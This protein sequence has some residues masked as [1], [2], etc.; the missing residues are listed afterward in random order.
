MADVHKMAAALELAAVW[1]NHLAAG[2]PDLRINAH[3]KT[4]HE[5]QEL[6]EHPTP[7]EWAD[8]AI[9]LV[10]T[11]LAQGWDADVLADAIAAKV[12]VN[13]RRR[14][15]QEPNGTWQHVPTHPAP[16]STGAGTEGD[17]QAAGGEDSDGR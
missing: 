4:A 14:W 13:A 16:T 5:A 17:T 1:L 3:R 9:C 11:A 8:V 7:E 2:G 6:A 12:A 10:G 15:Q